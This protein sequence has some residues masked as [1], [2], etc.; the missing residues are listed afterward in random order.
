MLNAIGAFCFGLVIG[1][2]TYRTLRRKEGASVS[3]IASIIGAVGGGGVTA[4]FGIQQF[5]PFYCIGLAAGFFGYFIIGLII[6]KGTADSWMM[7][8]GTS[9]SSWMEEKK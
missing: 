3:D 7:E 5:F 8:S 2:I 6:G 4:L 1:W 9:G